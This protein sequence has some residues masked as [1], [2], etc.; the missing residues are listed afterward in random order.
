MIWPGD[1]HGDADS[2]FKHGGFT[3]AEREVACGGGAIDLIIHIA[4]VVGEEDDDG[5]LSELEAVEGIDESSDGVV[6]CFDHGGVGG[7][8]L[9]VFWINERAIFFNDLFLGIEGC[10]DGK[11]PVVEEE[12]FVLILLYEGDGF[13]G[14]AVFNVLLWVI[15]IKVGVSPRSDEVSSGSGAV[16]V[17]DVDLEAVLKGGMG[18][19]SEVPLPE[20]SGGVAGVAERFAEGVV[21][22][23]EAV[24]RVWLDRFVFRIR[25]A[26]FSCGKNRLSRVTIWGGESSAG[27]IKPSENAGA[28][29]RT[30]WRGSVGAG[31][32]HAALG[33]TLDVWGLVEFGVAVEG[34]VGPAEVIGENEDDVWFFSSEALAAECDT[35][36]ENEGANHGEG[37]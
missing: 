17:W 30:E 32:C 31:E 18:S 10:V 23:V 21:F 29:G 4:S 15:G 3:A 33:E 20:V 37:N 36:D 25:C 16:P 19:G 22:C 12:G 28:R 24:H 1:D 26:A 2:A 14:H 7:A 11:H 34:G 8:V 27:R 9:R 13:F 6:H 35:G 5:I